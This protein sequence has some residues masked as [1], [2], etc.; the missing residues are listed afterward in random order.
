LEKS[1]TILIP[2][3]DVSEEGF[4]EM[5]TT[6]SLPILQLPSIVS[7]SKNFYCFAFLLIS[8]F[9]PIELKILILDT[10]VF[11]IDIFNIFFSFFKFSFFLH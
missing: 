11:N 6:G 1:K 5:S 8:V 9:K 4:V 2:N 3:P 10:D 7:T